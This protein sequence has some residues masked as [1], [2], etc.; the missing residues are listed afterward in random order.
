MTDG[1]SAPPLTDAALVAAMASGSEDALAALYDRHATGIHATAL[2]VTGDRGIAE[3]VIQKV[4]LDV[5]PQGSEY[6]C[7][8]EVDG[9]RYALGVMWWAGDVAWWAGDVAIPAD[10]PPGV[11]YGVSLVEEGLPGPGTVVL[12]GSL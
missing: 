12:T 1:R 7:W 4:F 9:T 6:R 5:P 10:I 11:V 8:V 2:R 3:D